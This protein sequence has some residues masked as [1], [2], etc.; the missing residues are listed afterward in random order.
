MLPDHSK[1]FQD[2]KYWADF[3]KRNEQA[4]GKNYEWYAEFKELKGYL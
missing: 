4:T 1:Q 2:Q 3:F